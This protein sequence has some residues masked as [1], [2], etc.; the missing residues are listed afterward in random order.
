MVQFDRC[1]PYLTAALAHGDEEYTLEDVRRACAEGELQFWPGERFAMVTR[2]VA[3]PRSRTLHVHLM[4]GDFREA[5]SLWPAI[6]AWARDA[7]GCT[8]ATMMGRP[9][10]ARHAGLRALGWTPSKLVPLEVSL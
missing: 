4:G 3:A 8:R 6:A 7:A 2:I 1:A 5:A 10:W 9:G